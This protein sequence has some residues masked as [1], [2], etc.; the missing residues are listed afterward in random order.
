MALVLTRKNGERIDF[1]ELGISIT[2][3]KI[4]GNR[5]SVAIEAPKGIKI[6]RSELNDKPPEAK[7]S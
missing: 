2:I 3:D 7:A 4:K 6:L 5:V 1:V